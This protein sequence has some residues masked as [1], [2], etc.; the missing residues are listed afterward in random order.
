LYGLVAA[1]TK[2]GMKGGGFMCTDN[3]DSCRRSDSNK[4]TD[5]PP[6]LRTIKLNKEDSFHERIGREG[7]EGVNRFCS[8]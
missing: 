7:A 6:H 1:R 2:S 8:E 5:V 3:S 4:G